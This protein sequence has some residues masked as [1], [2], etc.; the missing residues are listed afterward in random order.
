[1][2]GI[3]ILFYF[4]PIMFEY[5]DYCVFARTSGTL[6]L[7]RLKNLH[8]FLA[9]SESYFVS[10]ADCFYDETL[11]C[12]CRVRSQ[13]SGKKTKI[14]SEWMAPRHLTTGRDSPQ[15][16]MKPKTKGQIF[17]PFKLSSQF[18]LRGFLTQKVYTL[19]FFRS[20]FLHL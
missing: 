20:M 19:C 2:L 17:S 1:M 10:Q 3:F 13:V 12:E 16:S 15:P 6:F 8:L 11:I 7:S 14:I 9:I 18:W 5:C 4:L